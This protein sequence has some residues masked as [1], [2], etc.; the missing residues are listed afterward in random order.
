MTIE[1]S[2]A[3]MLQKKLTDGSV[4]KVIE[5]KLTRCIGECIDDMFRW[6]GPAKELIEQ[7]LKETMVPAIEKHDFSNYTLKLDSV[8]TDIVNSTTLQD[9]KK[10]LDNF[11]ELMIAD[12]K[13][14]INLSDIFEKWCDYVVENVDTSGLEVEYDDDVSYERVHVEMETEDIESNSRHSPDRKIVRFTCE[15]DEEMN[16]QFDI[17]KYDFMK[18]YEVSG[19]GI[20]QI[21]GL[22]RMDDMQIL[23]VRLTRNSTAIKLDEHYLEDDIR[24]ESKPEPTYS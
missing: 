5:E 11:K 15:H 13:K 1:N 10:I 12:D 7:K 4:E 14:E 6:S 22:V 9:N 20:A 2:I 8:L 24:P 16:L 3:E 23:L 17:Y 21:N 19:Y 18:G